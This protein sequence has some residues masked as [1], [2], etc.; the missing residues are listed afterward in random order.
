V[1]T[2]L[3]RDRPANDLSWLEEDAGAAPSAD[4]SIG[5]LAR[6]FGISLR[7]LR[8]Y[9]SKGLV[10]PRR[11]GTARLY[12]PDDRQRI[13]L[14]LQGKRLGF[15]L[16]EIRELLAERLSSGPSK[17]LK[18][19]PQQCIEQLKVLERQKN[20]LEEAI[21]VLKQTY[22]TL[23]ENRA[24]GEVGKQGEQSQG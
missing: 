12:S 7:T 23:C 17:D 20:E 15:T 18:L 24:A 4:F 14:V 8:F 21:S 5:D 11:Y 3:N 13:A 2:K 10:A 19:T 9:E 6:E 22:A 16:A 1:A